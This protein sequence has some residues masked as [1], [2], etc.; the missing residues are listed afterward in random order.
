MQFKKSTSDQLLAT[1]Y[2]FTFQS[3][4]KKPLVV[5]RG[6]NNYIEWNGDPMRANVQLEA[7]YTADNVSFGPL[8]A[9]TN[10]EDNNT[11]KARGDVY[12]ITILTGQLFKPNIAFRIEFPPGSVANSDPTLGFGVQ[13]IEKNPNELYKQVTYL[14]V[15]NSFAPIDSK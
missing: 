10:I 5:T 6:G 7:Q 14:I 13:Q 8:A 12:V 9:Y 1:L 15:F 4:F 3:F 11:A 2:L